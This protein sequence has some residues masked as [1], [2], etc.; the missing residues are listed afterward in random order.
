MG[1][2]HTPL[3]ARAPAVLK[4]AKKGRTRGI[5]P[6]PLCGRFF[7][8]LTFGGFSGYHPPHTH[9]QTLSEIRGGLALEAQEKRGQ[10][11]FLAKALLNEYRVTIID[12]RQCIHR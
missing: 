8:R 9:T 6:T 11:L 5:S 2:D 12:S 4:R 1:W 10:H 3:T 7:G